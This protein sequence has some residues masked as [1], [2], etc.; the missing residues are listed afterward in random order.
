VRST[1]GAR[2]RAAARQLSLGL[3]AA[4]LLLAGLAVAAFAAG[5]SASGGRGPQGAASA[6]DSATAS[7]RKRRRA[8]RRG[9][10][11]APA[12]Q[13]PRDDDSVDSVPA[14]SW[15]PVR[16]A[17]TYEFQLSADGAFRSIVLGQ[18]NGSF[19]TKNTAATINKTLPDGNYFWR[20]R[21]VNSRD[22]AGPWSRTRTVRKTWS[23][24]PR[25]E[26]P[27]GDTTIDYPR[28]LILSWSSIPRAY[29]YELEVATDPSLGSP[30]PGFAKPI[31]TSGTDFAVGLALPVGRYYWAVT[32]LNA[33][34]HK[35]RRS[36][37]GSFNIAWPSTTATRVEDLNGDERIYDPQFSWDAVPGAARY[38]V[39]I[40]SSD[41]F[42]AGSKVCCS[43]LTTGTSLS[44]K[45]VL[46]NNTG[47]GGGYFWRMRA[48]DVDG[49]AGV[50]NN[51]PSFPK[52][53]SPSTIP[54]V[55]NLH[56]RDHTTDLAPIGTPSAQY[57]VIAWDPSPGAASYELQ[58]T[59]TAS[60]GFCNWTPT[61]LENSQF[62]H[63]RTAS[64]AWTPL[65]NTW[66]GASP[67]GSVFTNISYDPGKALVPGK[68][69]C[70]RVRARG[71]RDAQGHEVVSP[72]TELG[73]FLAGVAS[74]QYNPPPPPSCA[75]LTP[76]QASDY[77][78]PAFGEVSRRMPFFAWHPVAGACSYFIVVAKDESFTDVVDVALTRDPV[79]AP[80]AGASPRTYPDESSSYYWAVIPS[81]QPNGGSVWTTPENNAPQQFQKRSIP[82]TPLGPVGGAAVAGQPSFRWTS[83]EGAREYRLQVAQDPSFGELLDD[84]TTDASSFT[85][86]STYPAET[87]LYW[88]V[89]ANDENKV[90]LAWSSVETFRRLLPA[91]EPSAGNPDGGRT[92]PLLTWSTVEGAV[93]YD[94]H[95]DQPD[96]TQRDFTVRSPA[97]TPIAH[98]GTGVWKWK[99]RANFPK[100]PFG[101]TPGAYSSSQPFTRFIGSPAGTRGTATSNRMLLSWDPVEMVKSYKVEISKTNSFSSTIES[102]TTDNTSYAPKLTSPAFADGGDLYWRVAS[103]DEG[104]NLGG[105]TIG[106]FGLPK[107]MLLTLSGNLRRGRRGTVKVKVTDTRGRKIRKAKVRVSGAGLRTVAK[108]T[109]RRGTVT[110][111]LR[112]RRKG[113][114]SFGASKGGYRPGSASLK[115]G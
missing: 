57:P 66:N 113:S 74:F 104:N 103:V 63:V 8:R 23:D 82:P 85:S 14:F 61:G 12:L 108:R 50:W 18:G 38:E 51:G 53:F 55:P 34:K 101:T 93:S 17:A 71:D 54:S 49:N 88:R 91:P 33:Q 94:L 68:K 76:T 114:V 27:A 13:A 90:G 59:L 62:W 72:W 92:I 11:R 58:V 86:S 6:D 78:S 80:R 77:I 70:V 112:P 3:I 36:A 22:D 16:G 87:T 81:P 2:H 56:V 32:P 102:Q 69:Y 96:G 41:E 1:P 7:A 37:V 20:V 98:Y 52:Y 110:F 21:A 115:V 73:N 95:V 48:I 65:S 5:G 99:V 107:R 109:T 15:A 84:V 29:K 60:S 35:G 39:E 75:Q 45:K 43:D 4:A 67:V 106:T 25:L 19:H 40:S 30:A 89:R 100:T 31:E 28:P 79:Y 44:P 105:W 26:S 64:T 9:G 42:A 111:R 24:V 46:P 97:F 83:A 47:P 10:L